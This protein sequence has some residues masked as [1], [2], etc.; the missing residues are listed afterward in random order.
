[1]LR[2]VETSRGTFPNVTPIHP[3]DRLPTTFA[4]V[5]SGHDGS[6]PF[7]VDDFVH[8]CVDRAIPP[9]NM[10]MAARYAVPEV[11]AHESA[12]QGGQLR[13]IPD[14]GDPPNGHT[15]TH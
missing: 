1:V 14:L 6:H 9:N 11:V 4:N 13:E 8:A 15:M 7:L 5:P 3:I 10:W 2:E 12:M